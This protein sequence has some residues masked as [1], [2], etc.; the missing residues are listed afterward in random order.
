[1]T[2]IRRLP[3]L[4]SLT[5]LSVS[6]HTRGAGWERLAPIPEP[7]G[8]FVCGAVGGNVVIAGGTNW[9]DDTKHWLDQIRVFEP[10]KNAWRDAG[11]LA[12][13][14]AYAAYGQTTDGLWFAG[15]SSGADTHTSRSRLDRRLNI[16]TSP[17]SGLRFVYSSGAILHSKL[18]VIGGA[19]DQAKLETLTNACYAID[20]RAG[21][22]G[23]K[24]TRLADLPVPGFITGA[25]AACGDRVFVFG[26]ACWDAAANMVTN[27][28]GTFAYLPT[29]DRWERLAPY[30]FEA[31]G[32]TAVALDSHH[33]F[34]GGG[35]KN[36]Q[37]EFADEAFIFDTS[38]GAFRKTTPLPYRALVG[39]VVNG[40][41]LY[42][43]G[44]EDRK[45]HRTDA[46]YRI[47][48]KELLKSH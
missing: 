32:L 25:A 30:P 22:N 5:M 27:M 12:A 43:L 42:C 46:A 10:R 36:D 1:M 38:A 39:L 13:P 8:G 35:Y 29:K 6:N 40:D 3:F 23:G 33:I 47:E 17:I 26:G 45:K 16:L 4:L 14:L 9:K 44:G 15:G 31:R 41:Q 37:E 24:A 28:S 20:L 21:L 11:R 7:N 18:Y 2:T 48:W 19:Q 34:I